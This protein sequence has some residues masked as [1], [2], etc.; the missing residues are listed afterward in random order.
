MFYNGKN[1]EG[2]KVSL[3]NVFVMSDEMKDQIIKQFVLGIK[4]VE[5]RVP[6]GDKE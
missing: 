4:A 1:P 6:E 3:H 5:V 2:I